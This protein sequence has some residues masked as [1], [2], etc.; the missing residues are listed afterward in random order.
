MRRLTV[1]TLF[2]LLLAACGPG[3][4]KTTLPAPT[5]PVA[6]SERVLSSDGVPIAYTVAGE[7]PGA[8]LFIHGWAC[9]RYYWASQLYDFADTHTVVTVDLAGHGDSGADR[10]EWTFQALARDVQAVVDHL[11]LSSVVLVGHSMGGPVALEAARL[12]PERVVGVIGVDTLHDVGLDYADEWER[13]FAAYETDFPGTCN[14]FV[15]GMFLEDADA[16]LVTEITDDM[17]DVSPEIGLALLRAYSVHDLPD[18][19]EG[20]EVPVR[21]INS[22]MWPTNVEG[23]RRYDPDFDVLIIEGSGHFPMR[24]KRADFDRLLEQVIEEITSGETT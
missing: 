17:C 20:V 8:L 22:S 6:H 5:G 12:M 14:Q 10:G 1:V 21:A 16:G 11:D 15:R 4:E 24:E 3:E 2:V 18:S 9:D 23:N 13:I 7:G 19:L